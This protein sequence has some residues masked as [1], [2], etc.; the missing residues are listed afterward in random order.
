MDL[1][2][3][4]A[5]LRNEM[6]LSREALGMGAVHPVKLRVLQALCNAAESYLQPDLFAVPHQKASETSAEAARNF[7]PK[8]KTKAFDVLKTLSHIDHTTRHLSYK[9]GCT[10]HEVC[11][12][13]GMLDST[14]CGRLRVLE[15]AGLVETQGQREGNNGANLQIYHITQRGKDYLKSQE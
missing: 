14:A 13:L 15:Q 11:D 1:L 12:I 8:A 10:R 2:K 6:T 7:R 3:E 9:V 4:I 5:S